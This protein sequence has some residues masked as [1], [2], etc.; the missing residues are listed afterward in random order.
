MHIPLESIFVSYMGLLE[1]LKYIIK[2]IVGS[3]EIQYNICTI[4]TKFTKI[5]KEIF[6]R[7]KNLTT[8]GETARYIRSGA[9]AEKEW[10][11]S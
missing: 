10:L 7:S 6:I 3:I 1:W 11:I 9:F 8:Y 5:S 4:A 2:V